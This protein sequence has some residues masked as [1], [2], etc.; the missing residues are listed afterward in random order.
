MA[1]EIRFRIIDLPF[2]A[3]KSIDASWVSTRGALLDDVVQDRRADLDRRVGAVA[4]ARGARLRAR[5]RRRCSK[6]TPRSAFTNLKSASRI[7]SSSLSRSRSRPMSRVSSH[8][9]RRRS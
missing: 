6:M 1:L 4:A 8:V 5:R 3:A 2:D 7:L 9:M